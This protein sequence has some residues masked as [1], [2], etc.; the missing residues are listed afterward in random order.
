[1][2]RVPLIKP[3]D[4]KGDVALLYEGAKKTTARVSNF[5]RAL[6]NSPRVAQMLLLFNN[7]LQ[8]EGVGSVLSSRIKEIVII[9]TSKLNECKY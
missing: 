9:K 4:A 6:A 2:A 8:R 1:M 3:E 5:Y 7:V